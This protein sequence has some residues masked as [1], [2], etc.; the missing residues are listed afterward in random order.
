L[1]I[2]CVD[3]SPLSLEVCKEILAA[4]GFKVLCAGSGPEALAFLKMHP[5]DAAVIDQHMPE[6]NGLDLAREMKLSNSGLK[7]VMYSGSFS[8]HDQLA[9]IDVCMS[10]GEG[11]LAL[12]R[13]LIALLRQ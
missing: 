12:R 6:M 5:V 11:P 13:R 1:T 3:D 7:I 9:G 8:C 2:L 10:K 4:G